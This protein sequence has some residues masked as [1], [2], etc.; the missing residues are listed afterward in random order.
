MAELTS[1]DV[2]T[3]ARAS[4]YLATIQF[5]EIVEGTEKQIAFA[6]KLRSDFATKIANHNSVTNVYAARIEYK[7]G[8]AKRSDAE[9]LAKDY[10][11]YNTINKI[12]TNDAKVIIDRFCSDKVQAV[13]MDRRIDII[14]VLTAK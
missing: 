10:L 2:L 3:R 13:M 12:N 4:E 1:K 8:T 7:K 9:T 14:K 5:P 6:N 11:D